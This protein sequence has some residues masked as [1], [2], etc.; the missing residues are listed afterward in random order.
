MAA[1]I[2]PRNREKHGAT[3]LLYLARALGDGV[4][5]VGFLS[6]REK[7]GVTREKHGVTKPDCGPTYT[8]NS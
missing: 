8:V 7:H 1:G 3:A 6:H 4:G 2:V 5:A